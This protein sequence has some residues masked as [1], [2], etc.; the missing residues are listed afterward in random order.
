MATSG[1]GDPPLL[2]S[3]ESRMDI[4]G[5]VNSDATIA[6]ETEAGMKPFSVFCSLT[7]RLDEYISPYSPNDA[8]YFR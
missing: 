7:L 3:I 5:K 4:L 1:S 2:E 8:Q 6:I